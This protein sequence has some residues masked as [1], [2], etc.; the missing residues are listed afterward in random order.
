M[1]LSYPTGR[2]ISRSPAK[3]LCGKILL[4]A[5]RGVQYQADVRDQAGPAVPR[6]VPRW[7]RGPDPDPAVVSRLYVQD[8]RTE[9][10]IAV[11]LSI[12]RARV[13]AVLR[14]AGIPRRTSRK[15]CPVDADTLREIVQA[16][17][18]V[19]AVAREYGVSHTTAARWFTEAGL[20]GADP[21][22]DPRLLRELYADR[23]LSTREVAAELGIN[24]ARVIRALTA[25]GIPRRP[26]SV[27]RARGAR[28]AVTDTA[29]A[30]VYR[31]PGM[32]IAKAAAHFGVSDEYLRRRIAETGLTRRPGTFTPRTAWSPDVLQA[33]AV[34][35][36]ATGMTMREVGARLGVAS[37]T[38]SMALHAA[39]APV[40]PSGGARPEAQGT[41]RTLI[42]D[43][44]ADP[45]V[46]AALRRHHVQVPDEADWHVTGPFHTYGPLPVP[47][48]LVRELYIDIGLSIRHIALLIG[49][50]DSATRSRLIQAGVTFRPSQERCPW[51]HRRYTD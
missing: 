1:T 11:L 33:K 48:A 27:R 18:T 12:S 4:M 7:W 17:G 10:E 35:L 21:G 44:Y 19:A 42:T 30:E 14:D 2:A 25:A 28:A 8:G 23:Q 16:G 49:L 13:A 32:T 26:R 34:K 39:K 43:L 47:A 9:T 46:V 6:S 5:R 40:R 24:K 15:D 36:Y 38:V 51:N 3:N 22:V 20:L 45:Y 50:G 31:R 37:S 41:P 29:L